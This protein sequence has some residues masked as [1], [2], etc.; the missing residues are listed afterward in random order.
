MVAPTIR[1]LLT[2]DAAADAELELRELRRAGLRVTHRIVD[3]EQSFTSALREFSPDLI[4]SDFTMPGFDGMAALSI[5]RELSPHTPFIFV[6]ATIGEEYAVR[7][8]Q[9]G[10]TDYV[11][12]SNL[13]RLPPAVERALAEA[14]ERRKRQRTEIEL[15]LAQ[16]RMTSVVTSIPDMLWSVDLRTEKIMYVSPA[17]KRIFGR[18]ADD[19]LTNRSL[20]LQVVYRDDQPRVKA[21]W[22]RLRDGEPFDINYRVVHTNGT[23]RWINNRGKTIR[24]KD[25][26]PQRAEGLVRDI[27]EQIEQRD[28]IERLSHIRDFSSRIN[29]TL[30]RVREREQLFKAI[31][32]IAVDEGGML[33]AVVGMLDPATKGIRWMEQVMAPESGAAFDLPPVSAQDYESRS[34]FVAQALTNRLPAISNDLMNDRVVRNRDL[35]LAHGAAS[36]A[37]FPLIVDSSVAGLL[38]LYASQVGFFDHDEVSLLT[39]LAANV[40]FALELLDKQDRITYLGLYDP[41]TGLANQTLFRDRLAE[42]VRSAQSE[43]HRFAV[44]MFDV[45]RF[46]VINDTQGRLAG[47]QLLRQIAER[48]IASVENS[49]L[50]GRVGPD[51]FAFMIPDIQTDTDAARRLEQRLSACFGSAF[52]IGKGELRASWKAGLSLFPTDG[53]NQ[54]SLFANA[55]AAWKRAKQTG[56]PYLFYTQRMTES[57][58]SNLTLENKLRLALERQEFV[59]YYQ[60]KIRL[61]TRRITGVEALIRW[62][63]P[64]NGLVPPAQFIPLMEET[65]LILQVGAW[66]LSQAARDYRDWVDRGLSAPRIAV[67]VSAI[68]LRQR[69]FVQV[70]KDAISKDGIPTGVDLEITESRLMED[71]DSNIDKLK[72]LRSLA[73]GISIDDFGTGHSS[74]AYLAKLPVDTIKI[75]RSFIITMLNDPNAMTLVSTMI[76]LAHSLSLKVVAEG[77]DSEEQEKTLAR[78]GCDEMQGYLFSKPLPAAQLVSLLRAT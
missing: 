22:S 17:A 70:V 44:C 49:A 60:P 9:S 57:V 68:Q 43:G 14:R 55:E 13:L 34:G 50:V 7:A 27:T 2:E 33:G 1:V 54:E 75:D 63:S 67:N 51:R 46:K 64:D 19:F 77:V 69:D 71:I 25:G 40:S 42:H 39:E 5:A 32:R 10:A 38:L 48:I 56:D 41:L 8:L 6:S 23:V 73:L 16:E 78:L 52:S 26:S 45:D 35:F 47:D 12:K 29:S 30:V 21:A 20:W 3:N 65:G 61:D 58:A 59:L 36:M 15:E 31:C 11:L 28:R 76:S 37:A 72:A 62:Q 18:D 24:G 4:L 53:N 74:L 66:A